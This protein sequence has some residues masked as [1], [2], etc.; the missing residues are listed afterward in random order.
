MRLFNLARSVC[1]RSVSRFTTGSTVPCDRRSKPGARTA[2]VTAVAVLLY[3]YGGGQPGSGTLPVTSLDGTS[4]ASVR[5]CHRVLGEHPVP[6]AHLSSPLVVRG[7]SRAVGSAWLPSPVVTRQ[8]PASEHLHR[9]KLPTK[10][11]YPSWPGS[12]EEHAR[13]RVKR[14]RRRRLTRTGFRPNV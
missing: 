3:L 12:I 1:L 6:I 11:S 9:A 7:Q 13:L 4:H 2:P 8:D 5:R 14:I 10:I